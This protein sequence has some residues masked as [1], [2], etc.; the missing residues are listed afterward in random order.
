MVVRTPLRS[1]ALFGIAFAALVSPGQTSAQGATR[2]QPSSTQQV[3]ARTTIDPALYAQLR[4]R[5][6][7]PVGNRVSSVAGV[8]GDP[9]TYYAG[10]ASGGLFKTTDGGIHWEPVF[11]DKP[12]SSIGALAVAPSNP[13]IVWAGTG[14]P[15]VRSHISIGAGVYKSTDAGRTWALMGLEATGRIGRI[16]IHPTNPD[17]VWIAA[18]GHSYGPQQDRGVYRTTDGGRTWQRTLFVDENTG[19]IDIVVHPTN[20][21]VL[22]AA[23]WQLVIRTWGRESGGPGSGI[24]VSRDGGVTWNRLRAPGLPTRPVGKIGL[25]IAKSNPNRMYALIE[26]G[27]GVPIHG[28]PTDPG[29]LWRSDDG[30]A[31]WRVASYNRNL[32]C[33]HAYYTRM[34]VAPDNPDETYFLCASFY[35]S[36]DGGITLA[37]LGQGGNPGGDNH[38]M[39][40][41]PTNPARMIIGNDD[42]VVISNT[43]TRSWHRIQ[44]PI[45][46]MYHVEVDNQIPYYVYGNQQDGPS[47]RGPSNSRSGGTIERSEWHAVGGGESGWA[48]PD[49]V[50]PNIIWS[51]SSG[52]GSLGGIVV[53]FDERTRQGHNVE[54][55]PD[56]TGGAPAAEVKY[57]FIWTMPLTISP[58]DR[59]KIYVGSQHVHVTTNGGRSWQVISPDLT[60]N[61]K[62]MQQI[63]GGL[64]PDNIGVEYG[65][66]IFAIA[67]SRVTP[68]L[69]W[70]GTND[71][72]VQLTRDGG[73]TWTNLS[74][75]I[76]GM[77]ARGTISNIEPSKYDAGTAYLTVDAHQENNRDPWVYRTT[78]F[79]RTWKL[80]VNGIPKSPLSYAHVVREDPVRR[81]M[82]YLGTENA[83]YVTFDDGE[84]WQP[85]QT[86]LPP[87]PVYWMRVQE[88]FNDLVVGT[89][90]RG[91]WIMDD[92]SALQQLTPQVTAAGAHLFVPRAAYRFRSIPGQAATSDDPT[93][94]ENPTYG[95][96]INY[97][98]R[99]PAQGAVT[100][101][102]QNAQGQ[103]IRTLAGTNRPG[104]NRVHWDL[105]NEPTRA[106]RLR[107]KPLYA[108]D[109]ELGSDSTRP[110][111]GFGS[112]SVLMPPGRYTVKLSAGGQEFTQPLEVRADPNVGAKEEE[113]RA[114][115]QTLLQLHGDINVVADMVNTIEVVRAQA[116]N[117]VSALASDAS[118][119]DVRTAADSLER[120]FTALE[121]HLHQLKLTGQGQDG[122][123]WPSKLGSKMVYL[124]QGIAS[125]DFAPTAQ[126]RE[127]HTLFQN[128]MRTHRAAL[129]KLI[130]E[131][132][133]RYNELARRR[134]GR[135]I[136]VE[137]PRMVF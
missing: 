30:G 9:L 45:A 80:I 38:D 54:V 25:A 123:R 112:L 109:I 116:Q 121:E 126:Q 64:T 118:R 31:N 73:R 101:T 95:A 10:A 110:A 55:W 53:R 114:Q 70:V 37:S 35:K 135:V 106:A 2:S 46:Q 92:L 74:R 83:L 49:P 89:Y 75:N 41:D 86:N 32:G 65:N 91:F 88:H 105:R 98:L 14:E 6:V 61:D 59:N 127:V 87:A 97:W 57:R 36:L 102:I 111:P 66:T 17:I 44:L 69:I 104:I 93:A 133:A 56:R 94:G 33:R 27:D 113:I 50:D 29:E 124:G 122:V 23:T 21:N 11:D 137:L 62:S 119:A 90:G 26:T 81:G 117:A 13:N 128:E 63:S 39:W 85:L 72:L 60:L 20:P 42:G 8:I 84:S 71:G 5:H 78:D 77:P 48:T 40:I 4:Y 12:V 96:S 108:P 47:W 82:L 19:A 115:T 67:E 15:W 129:E 132:L 79:G 7:G 125:S 58:H 131:D 34:D 99:S 134:G 22:Y 103:T 107:T 120:K 18:Q 24:F 130:A 136:S 52:S 76:P 1:L 100:L 3:S 51:S 43:R 28:Q 16:V 68:G